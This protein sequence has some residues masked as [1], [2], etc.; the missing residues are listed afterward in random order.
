MSNIEDIEEFWRSTSEY[1]SFLWP[2]LMLHLDPASLGTLLS[3][4]S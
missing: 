4:A 1:I 2:S 3:D